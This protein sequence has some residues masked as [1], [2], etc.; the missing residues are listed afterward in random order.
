MEQPIIEIKNAVI[1]K[2]KGLDPET[3]VFL[4]K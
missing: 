2:L 4:R 3:D 1:Q